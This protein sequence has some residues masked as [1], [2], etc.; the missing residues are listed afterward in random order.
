MRETR[1]RSLGREDPLGEEMAIHSSTLEWKIPWTEEPGRLQS[2]GSQRVGHDWTTSLSLSWDQQLCLLRV[3][4]CH[5]SLPP[6]LQRQSTD[7]RH[8]CCAYS[9]VNSQNP[10][11]LSASFRTI[12][13]LP[14]GECRSQWAHLPLWSSSFTVDIRL[15]FMAFWMSH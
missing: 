13:A 1:V 8:F 7:W 3:F 6:H 11:P 12:F 14:W 9:C 2:M 4:L 5:L 10:T 15:R